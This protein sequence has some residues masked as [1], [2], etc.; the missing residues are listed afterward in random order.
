V[1]VDDLMTVIDDVRDEE[2][3]RR[4][5]LNRSDEPGVEEAAEEW[6]ESQRER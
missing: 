4:A 5:A 6:R 1:D 2:A 3:Y